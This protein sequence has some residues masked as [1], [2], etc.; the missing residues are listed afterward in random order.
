MINGVEQTFNQR[1]KNDIKRTY[2]GDRYHE[3]QS[4]RA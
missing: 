3:R 1:R 4:K 2:T